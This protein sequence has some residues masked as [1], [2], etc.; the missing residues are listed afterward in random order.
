MNLLYKSLFLDKIVAFP[1]YIN[2]KIGN[3][4]FEKPFRFADDRDKESLL[5]A[6]N[7]KLLDCMSSSVVVMNFE[8]I[9]M[10]YIQYENDKEKCEEE[11]K[12]TI[13]ENK[14][15]L[16]KFKFL[17]GVPMHDLF[18][19]TDIEED[20]ELRLKHMLLLDLAHLD[21]LGDYDRLLSNDGNIIE[22][23]RKGW[24]KF[25]IGKYNEITGSLDEEL[26]STKDES[27]ITDLQ[28]IKSILESVPKEA[29]N[30]L[31][32]KKTLDEIMDYW[33]TLLLPKVDFK[34]G[35][36]DEA[37]P[38]WDFKLKPVNNP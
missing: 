8:N 3:Y 33:P 16:S 2:Y 25:I 12:K 32:S 19:R 13:S 11:F 28:S 9:I 10:F 35:I 26:K 21:G 20:K 23:F 1:C 18:F 24:H 22:D 17:K 30:D 6:I 29:E 5:E 37:P 38:N 7:I 14:Q 31:Q 15:I 27:I 34:L 36:F 4:T